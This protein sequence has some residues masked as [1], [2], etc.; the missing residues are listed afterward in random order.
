MSEP[1]I[2]CPKCN[3]EIKF[4]ESLAAP[5]IEAAEQKY[6]KI[7]RDKDLEIS[8]QKKQLAKEKSEVEQQIADGIEKELKEIRV[9]EEK[10]IRRTID[11]ELKNKEKE[12]VEAR[13]YIKALNEKLSVS[14]SKEAEL[15]KERRLLDDAKREMV[16]TIEKKVQ[17]EVDNI[18]QKARKEA[19]TSMN[20][21]VREKDLQI[22]S[23]RKTITE[24]ERK[25]TQ[26]SQQVQGEA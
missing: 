20:L 2:T 10:K 4:T 16:L 3:N 25:A 11:I 18:H 26:G 8:S 9:E 7:L 17:E 24:L 21:T 13:E 6:T 1:A 22:A 12:V 19:E 23:M 15:L 5:L 14:Q